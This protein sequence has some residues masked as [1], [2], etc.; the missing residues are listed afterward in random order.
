MSV[1]L[2]ALTAPAI[3]ADK[4][5]DIT[6]RGQKVRALLV[7]PNGAPIGAVVRLAGGAGRLALG[8]NGAIGGG[9]GNQLVRTRA[10][11]AAAGYVALVPDIAP[12][13]K[14]PNDAVVSGYR[15]ADKNA[16]D[17]GEIGRAHV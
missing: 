8:A 14:L 1:A 4:V 16:A 7:M 3:A 11:Y 12:D 5:I 10:A 2:L 15:G 6:S 17:I 9:A 13:L